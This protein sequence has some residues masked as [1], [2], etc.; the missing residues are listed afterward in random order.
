MATLCSFLLPFFYYTGCGASKSELAAKEKYKQDSIQAAD[1][2][3]GIST[4][5]TES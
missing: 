5:T 4:G 3:A 1:S 2:I